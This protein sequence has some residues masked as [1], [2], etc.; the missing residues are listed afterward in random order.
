MRRSP[1]TKP[2]TA[3]Q[4]T[5]EPCDPRLLL[6]TLPISGGASA[7]SGV[8]VDIEIRGVVLVSGG[9]AQNAQLEGAVIKHHDLHGINLSNA[10]LK[11]AHLNGTNFSGANFFQADLSSVKAQ[12]IKSGKEKSR[13]NFSNADFQFAKLE[14]ADFTG[15]NLTGVNFRNAVFHST[16][17]IHIKDADL[18]GAVGLEDWKLKDFFIGNKKTILP[19]GLNRPKS[20]H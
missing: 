7:R 8:H 10:N 1:G 20:W 4:P 12:E 9:N 13:T 19:T 5:V 14:G 15:A 18:S 3:F 2:K 6:S 11:D 16:R 17:K